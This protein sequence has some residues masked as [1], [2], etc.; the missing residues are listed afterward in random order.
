[1]RNRAKGAIAGRAVMAAAALAS[2]AFGQAASATT[3]S[4][5]PVRVEVPSQKQFCSLN[6]TNQGAEPVTV[7]VRGYGWQKDAEG[8]DVLDENAGVSV[9]P[10]IVAIPAGAKQLIRCSLP[11]RTGATEQTF[12]LLINELPVANSQSGTVR[13]LLQISV[14]VFRAPAGASPALGWFTDPSG[15][16]VMV[17]RGN[18]HAQVTGVKVALKGA[19]QQPLHLERGFYLLSGGKFTLAPI[20]GRAG[21]ISSVEVETVGGRLIASA[22]SPE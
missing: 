13:A 1:M 22:V 3:L 18:R 15:R 16:I 17:N 19:N 2:M 9:N 4:V 8:R 14:P 5:L 21:E 7:Q 10:S 12:R 20:I 6:I 11:P